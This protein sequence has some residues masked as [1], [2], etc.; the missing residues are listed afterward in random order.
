MAGVSTVPAVLDRLVELARLTVD[1][2]EQVVDGQPVRDITN[3]VILIGFTGEPGE[4]AVTD[5]RT[6]GQMSSDPD[7]ESYEITC[8]AS[9]WKGREVHA[10]PPRDGAYE[11][12]DALNDELMRTPNLGMAGTVMRARLVTVG[13]TQQQTTD[14]ATATVRFVIAVSAYT[15]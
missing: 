12:V 14:G 8:L 15:R 6:R 7:K 2:P 4:E 3:D 9:S 11:L 1:D 10:K 13:L 5:T